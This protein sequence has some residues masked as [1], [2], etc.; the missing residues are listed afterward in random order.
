[1]TEVSFNIFF[2]AAEK[3]K[4]QPVSFLWSQAGD[5]Y[6]LEEKFALGSGFPALLAINH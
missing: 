4:G 5:Q 3:Y 1:M 2:Q 6:E